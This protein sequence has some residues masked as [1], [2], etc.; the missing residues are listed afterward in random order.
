MADAKR[1]LDLNRQARE[2]IPQRVLQ[3]EADHDRADRGRGQHLL[4][5]EERCHDCEQRDGNRILDDG[6]K[7]IGQAISRHGLIVTTTT[8][9]ASA[10]ARRSGLNPR[11]SCATSAGSRPYV[12]SAAAMA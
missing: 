6:R 2:E 3:R 5:H 7:T 12:A 1:L 10:K 8:S 11:I 9:V 4:L